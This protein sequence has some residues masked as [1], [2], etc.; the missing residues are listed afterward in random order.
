METQE[1]KVGQM[2]PTIGRIVYYKLSAGD[3]AA[4][5][6]RREDFKNTGVPAWPKGAQAHVGNPAREGATVPLIVTAVWP[7]EYGEGTFGVNGQAL[8]DGNDVLWITSA[9]QGEEAGQWDWMPFQKQQ[10]K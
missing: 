1:N 9:K 7:G 8:L 2:Q 6:R 4:I 10:Q 5:S 3:V